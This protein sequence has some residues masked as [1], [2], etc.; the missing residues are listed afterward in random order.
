LSPS[1]P[2]HLALALSLSALGLSPGR[3]GAELPPWAYG[4]QQRLAPVVVNLR[5]LG[6]EREGREARVRG[7]VLRVWRQP[8]SAL[9]TGQTLTIRYSLP[10]ERAPGWAGPS[11]LPLPR[12]GEELK[13]WLQP[14]GGQPAT[15]APAAGGRSFGPS[16]ERFKTP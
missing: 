6:A 1:F 3:V 11:P 14:I 7:R 13:A 5:V 4:E 2:R 16:L 8:A 10:P 12:Q 15:F 9:K